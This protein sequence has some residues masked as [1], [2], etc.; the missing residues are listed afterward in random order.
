[1]EPF[2]ESVGGIFGPNGGPHNQHFLHSRVHERR[3]LALAAVAFVASCAAPP[4]TYEDVAQLPR[5]AQLVAFKAAS[6][7]EKA[8]MY[9]G[10]L[11]RYAERPGL[12]PPQRAACLHA[13]S[14]VTPSDYAPHDSPEWRSRT[15]DDS[16][17]RG[18]RG[19]FGEEAPQVLYNL[20]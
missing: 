2:G 19:A 15:V 9:R 1:M 11:A 14:L 18:I 7:A 20:D 5:D 10:H 8:A 12:T 17:V 6:P 16:D 3:P 13:A 4:S